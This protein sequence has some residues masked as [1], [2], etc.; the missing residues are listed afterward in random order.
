MIQCCKLQ[1]R[2]NKSK[3]EWM[4]GPV[5]K[6]E[7]VITKN[8]I[9][10]S[11][12]NVPKAWMMEK[13][14][15]KFKRTQCLKEH[16]WNKHWMG[17]NVYWKSW[18][19]EGVDKSIRWKIQDFNH[20]HSAKRMKIN[21]KQQPRKQNEKLNIDNCKY[22]GAAHNQSQ[23]PAFGK[24]CSAFGKQKHFI[25]VCQHSRGWAWVWWTPHQPKHVH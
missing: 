25:V 18:G 19:V 22:C 23:C 12:H 3:Q 11:K 17:T 15:K 2:K 24:T 8:M 20:I 14:C 6:R 4:V 16:K 5:L 1:R 7:K 13:L 10:S 21:N 9:D